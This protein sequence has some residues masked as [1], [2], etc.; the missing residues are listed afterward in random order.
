[1]RVDSCFRVIRDLS[2]CI[3][4]LEVRNDSYLSSGKKKQSL[5]SLITRKQLSNGGA[6]L[7]TIRKLKSV[8]TKSNDI[9]AIS[10]FV[11]IPKILNFLKGSI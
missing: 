5:K 3:S 6:K 2:D 1:M 8:Y 7:L 4:F 9:E 11:M 10:L